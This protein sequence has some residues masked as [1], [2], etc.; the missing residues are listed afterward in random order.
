MLAERYIGQVRT[1]IGSFD[2]AW[3]NRY[4]VF[5]SSTRKERFGDIDIGVVG[6]SR[7]RKDIANLKEQFEES[8]V[9]YVVD[10]V[11]FDD[12]SEEFKDYVMHN[13]PLVW[14]N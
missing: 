14:L 4:F 12:A 8:T 10:V 2:P 5:G 1:I 6:N 3:Q 13:E 7:A 9:P 11:D